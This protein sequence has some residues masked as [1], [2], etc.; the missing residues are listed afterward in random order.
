MATSLFSWWQQRG[1]WRRTKAEG[2]HLIREARRILKHKSFRIPS[3]AAEGVTLAIQDAEAAMGGSDLD[4]LR[5]ALAG[6][7]EV[8]EQKLAFARKSTLR[9]YSESIG[10]A[11]AISCLP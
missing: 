11:I 2:R 9:E 10:I 1:L 6:L 8:M 7:D 5:S 3:A 4:R